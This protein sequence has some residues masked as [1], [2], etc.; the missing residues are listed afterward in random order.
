MVWDHFEKLKA[1]E[2]MI[3]CD[4][5]ERWVKT[6]SMIQLILILKAMR[7]HLSNRGSEIDIYLLKA[8]V[9]NEGDF[10]ILQWWKKNSHR[11]EVLSHMARDILVIPVSTVASESAFSIEG[12]AVDSSRC[13]LA[14]KTVEAL[15]C[16]RNWLNSGP[17]D[18]EVQNDME[19]T[20]LFEEERLWTMNKTFKTLWILQSCPL[21]IKHLSFDFI[22][23]GLY[24]TIDFMFYCNWVV[25]DN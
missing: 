20:S 17:I 4:P 9:K 12:R 25:F 21:T 5:T 24:L 23:I 19:E 2:T 1:S 15:I 13:S 18:L 3:D 7:L 14:P 8:N 22:V 10:D 6:L 16:T 11:F